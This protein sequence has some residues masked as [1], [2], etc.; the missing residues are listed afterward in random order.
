[1]LNKTNNAIKSWCAP[2]SNSIPSAD[3]LPIICEI[4]GIS[5]N[6]IFGISEDF[7]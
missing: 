3:D 6:E 1:M 7:V 4:I 5:L 2:N